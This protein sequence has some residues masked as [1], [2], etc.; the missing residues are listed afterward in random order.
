MLFQPNG[1]FGG[2]SGGPSHHN[3]WSHFL[4]LVHPSP[5]D[6]GTI[7]FYWKSKS[8]CFKSY[9][10][11]TAYEICRRLT[12]ALLQESCLS[13]SASLLTPYEIAIT[14]TLA[15]SPWPY[16]IFPPCRLCMYLLLALPNSGSKT[17][18]VLCL[19]LYH[20]CL[21]QIGARGRHSTNMCWMNQLTNE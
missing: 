13:L 16:L 12:T 2:L 8:E 17:S 14:T 1:P 6:R 15:L 4:L 19:L 3:S 7:H 5:S 10:K 20:Q 21:E 18:F 11:T 9:I